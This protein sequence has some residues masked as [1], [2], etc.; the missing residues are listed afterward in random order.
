MDECKLE[1][2]GL[3]VSD[4]EKSA[5]F[6]KNN[7]GFSEVKSFSKP[8]LEIKGLIMTLGDS[9]IELLEPYSKEDIQK[10]IQEN[11][12]D[13][14]SLKGLFKKI[15]SCHIALSVPD[16]NSAYQRIKENNN[17]RAT[18]I[19]EGGYFFCRDPDNILLE[20]RQRK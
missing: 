10:G 4:I 3:I 1:H 20:V 16:I 5:Q 15:A 11:I 13:K 17:T 2:V 9:A 8:D 19:I 6:Y 7:F 12:E 14:K 18:E